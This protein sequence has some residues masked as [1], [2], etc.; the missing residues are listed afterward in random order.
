MPRPPTVTLMGGNK[1]IFSKARFS[2]LTTTQLA[3][4]LSQAGEEMLVCGN[5]LR[6]EMD[7][8]EANLN[9]TCT[10]LAAQDQVYA[11]DVHLADGSMCQDPAALKEVNE[12]SAGYRICNL[13]LVGDIFKF[14][15]FH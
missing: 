2:T 5:C 10:S 13:P 4:N 7:L 3:M 9:T 1:G 15:W 14:G 11:G 6:H 12:T 8:T